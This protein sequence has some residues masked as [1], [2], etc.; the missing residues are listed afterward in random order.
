MFRPSVAFSPDGRTLA[1]GDDNG[2]IGLWATATGRKTDTLADGSA[3]HSVAFS[4]NSPLI[5]S[6]DY[7]GNVEIWNAD[8]GQQVA[9][10][11]ES[12]TV[13]SI[14]FS[15]H[16]QILA[17]GGLN[18]N[19]VLLRLNQG[20]LNRAFFK[21]LICAKVRENMTRAQWAQYAP[22]QPYQRTCS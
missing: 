16:D 22:G 10:L 19:I 5:A 18:N 2:H 9:R 15:A 14:M 17:I 13:T 21:H 12:G 6:G 1:A 11:G 7:S 3:V 4:S 20:D 8:N